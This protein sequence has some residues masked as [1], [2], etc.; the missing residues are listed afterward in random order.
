MATLT[1]GYSTSPIYLPSSRWWVKGSHLNFQQFLDLF[2]SALQWAFGLQPVLEFAKTSAAA[3]EGS[4]QGDETRPTL[5][6]NHFRNS[7][8]SPAP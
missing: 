2:Y 6:R 5:A 1:A 7:S 4:M 8:I 3:L